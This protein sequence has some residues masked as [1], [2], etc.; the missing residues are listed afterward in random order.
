MRLSVVKRSDLLKSLRVQN[1]SWDNYFMMLAQAVSVKSKDPRTQ[2]GC[3][4]VD[5]DN[6]IISTGFNGFPVGIQDDDRL[7]DRDTKL[8]LIIHAEVNA[9]TFARRDLTGCTLYVWPIPPCSR[10]A[11]QIIQAGIKRVVSPKATGTW[12]LS[13]NVGNDLFKE[14]GVEY[15]EYN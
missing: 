14:A 9:L 15:V 4:I 13:C 7:V 10:C 11:V 8:E 1:I 2:V 12:R 5:N 3:V 6:R